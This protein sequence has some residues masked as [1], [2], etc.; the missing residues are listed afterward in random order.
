MYRTI[1][2]SFWTDPKVKHLN[3]GGKLLLLY[4]ITN[5]HTHVSGIYVLPRVVIQL[6]TC[7][8]GKGIDTLCDT[9]SSLEIALFDPSKDVV[10]VKNMLSYQGRGDKNLRSAAAHVAEDLHNSFLCKQFLDFYPAV[11]AY[12]PNAALDTLLD[13]LSHRV[14]ESGTPDQ[15]QDTEQE[16]EQKKERESSESLLTLG[17]FNRVRITQDQYDKLK[18]EMNGHLDSYIR[19]FDAWVNE[20]PDAKHNGV[21]RRDR[22]A[23][24]SIGSWYRKHVKDGTIKPSVP[25]STPR[26]T[27]EQIEAE[28]LKTFGPRK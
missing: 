21:R 14:S 25:V 1:A 11:K 19:D 12:V 10:W 28:R 16:Q 6:E 20:A 26:Y 5:P 3:S 8:A 7:I 18:A 24:E 22:H 17:E 27:R 2:S 13:T 4:L 23:Y 9:L 15:D